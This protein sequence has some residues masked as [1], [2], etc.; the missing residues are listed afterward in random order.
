MAGGG[1]WLA[2]G[3]SE[4]GNPDTSYSCG[5]RDDGRLFCWGGGSWGHLGDGADGGRA[6]APQQVGDAADWV[7]VSVGAARACAL[8]AAGEL[9]CWGRNDDGGL[10]I[11]TADG[12]VHAPERV[13]A[14][15]AWSAVSVSS[16][17]CATATD[18]TLWCWGWG[19]GGE[20]GDG[21][22]WRL[23]PTQVTFGL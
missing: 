3:T 19:E 9:W 12:L 15:R 5:V 10:G 13:G 16:H 11:G 4:G 21:S 17:T 6:P 8:D 2:V 18:G 23:V 20:L 22:A 7:T 14:E 1:H